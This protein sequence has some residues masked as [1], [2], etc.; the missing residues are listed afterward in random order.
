MFSEGRFVHHASTYHP[1]L[2]SRGRTARS[3]Y[4]YVA[5]GDAI[6]EPVTGGP[7][8]RLAGCGRLELEPAV[9]A[10]TVGHHLP[11]AI[12]RFHETILSGG[13]GGIA[14]N[15][16]MMCRIDPGQVA[17]SHGPTPIIAAVGAIFIPGCRSGA[18]NAQGG[19]D[20]N[21]DESLVSIHGGFLLLPRRKA[22]SRP[23]SAD[24]KRQTAPVLY[25][26]ASSSLIG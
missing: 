25:L 21:H 17:R 11:S 14:E 3:G 4:S 9:S 12:P 6:L 5:I 18:E 10:M 22:D 8:Q 26:P 16:G 13:D 2:S 19:G 7:L 20:C 15:L 1:D 23:V 24:G